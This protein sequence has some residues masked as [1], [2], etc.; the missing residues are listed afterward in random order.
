MS[1]ITYYGD[2]DEMVGFCKRSLKQLDATEMAMIKATVSALNKSIVSTRAFMVREVSREYAIKQADV[3]GE[4]FLKKSNF[5]K[6]EASVSGEGKPGIPSMKFSPTPKRVPSTLRRGK[7][8][9][10]SKGIKVMIHRG[11]RKVMQGA[12][13]ARMPS[14]HV[15]VFMRAA[16]GRIGPRSRRTTIEEKF[17][18]SPLRMLENAE[19]LDKL[20]DFTQDTYDRNMEHEAEYYLRREG[21]LK[22]A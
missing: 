21:L 19:I 15:G 11:Q 2:V 1:L 9:L 7:R 20:D 3:R 6:L 17:S 12:F 16:D 13:I 14:G 18:P 4:L 5:K 8:Y 22:D 10:P